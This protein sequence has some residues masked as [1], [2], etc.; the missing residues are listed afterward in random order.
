MTIVKHLLEST[1]RF[2]QLQRRLSPVSTRTLTRQLR[3]LE[4]DGIIHREVFAE[5]PPRVEYS[6]TELG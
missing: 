4:A 1:L 6:L 3:D 2:G 5:V